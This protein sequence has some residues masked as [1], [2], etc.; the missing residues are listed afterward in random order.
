MDHCGY[1]Q[2]HLLIVVYGLHFSV[3]KVCILLNA[4]KSVLCVSQH[5]IFDV[6][7]PVFR[8]R[9]HLGCLFQ[10]FVFYT[11]TSNNSE[12]STVHLCLVFVLKRTANQWVFMRRMILLMPNHSF[13]ENVVET[14]GPWFLLLAWY[15][16]SMRRRNYQR[17][18]P[19]QKCLSASDKHRLTIN[20]FARRKLSYV[21]FY[22]PH[23]PCQTS[24]IWWQTSKLW[25]N[26]L[27]VNKPQF[28]QWQVYNFLSGEFMAKPQFLATRGWI[29]THFDPNVQLIWHLKYT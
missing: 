25:G 18:V 26:W 23:C 12:R 8:D 20:H 17:T 11:I 4:L 28:Y 9:W 13:K 1:L 3:D 16:H 6:L 29:A 21:R 5:N 19:L 24:V 2:C 22:H 14:C 27:F 7:G 15:P 10:V